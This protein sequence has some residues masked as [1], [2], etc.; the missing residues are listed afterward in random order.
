MVLAGPGRSECLQNQSFDCEQNQQR[1]PLTGLEKHNKATDLPT[2][3]H[4]TLCFSAYMPI[5]K[6]ITERSAY[7]QVGSAHLWIHP[8]AGHV[9]PA[10]HEPSL[11]LQ[12]SWGLAAACGA[13]PACPPAQEGAQAV[14]ALA[15]LR[16]HWLIK[17]PNMTWS[18]IAP[19]HASPATW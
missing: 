8:L 13:A 12:A 4:K 16:T 11:G 2:L 7:A 19:S 14:T 6:S 10:P 1:Q 5:N 15:L 17:T 3:A 9:W 18:I